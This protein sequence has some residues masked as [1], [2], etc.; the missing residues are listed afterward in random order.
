MLARIRLLWMPPR[1]CARDLLYTSVGPQF[2]VTV[3]TSLCHFAPCHV[4]DHVVKHELF[5]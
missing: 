2:P 1:V 5:T 4:V 3:L